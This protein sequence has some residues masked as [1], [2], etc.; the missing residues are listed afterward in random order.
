[1]PLLVVNI[2]RQRMKLF[3][4]SSWID[5]YS[6]S[7]SPW[8][9]GWS[10]WQAGSMSF[11]VPAHVPLQYCSPLSVM[12]LDGHISISQSSALTQLDSVNYL[13]EALA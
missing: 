13:E 4:N 2:I 1:M 5:R 7:A 3:T 8:H 11:L 10:H 6:F 9:S 12:Q